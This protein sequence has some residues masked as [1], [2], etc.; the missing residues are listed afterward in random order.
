MYNGESVVYDSNVEMV[1][2]S[3]ICDV[4]VSEV[5]ITQPPTVMVGQVIS[6]RNASVS[7]SGEQDTGH[8]EAV[9]PVEGKERLGVFDIRVYT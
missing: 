6:E 2:D 1:A 4:S 5:Q 7:I 9:V 3:E 8:C